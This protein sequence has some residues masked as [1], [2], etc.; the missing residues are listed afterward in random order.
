MLCPLSD[1][2]KSGA[3][4]RLEVVCKHACMSVSGGEEFHKVFHTSFPF[5]MGFQSKVLKQFACFSFSVSTSS[6]IFY[7]SSVLQQTF[8]LFSLSVSQ[9]EQLKSISY[10]EVKHGMGTGKIDEG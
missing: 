9:G 8:I 2:A 1:S 4:D 6:V 7:G 10:C 5:P 3:I